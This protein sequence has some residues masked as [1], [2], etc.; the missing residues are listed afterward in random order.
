MREAA[1]CRCQRSM[2]RP[3]PNGEAPALWRATTVLVA[4]WL[5]NQIIGYAV[6]G[7]PRT[8][9]SV[10]WGLAIGV[11]AVASTMIAQVIVARRLAARGLTQAVVAL[12]GTFAVYEAALSSCS[13]L[14]DSGEQGASPSRSSPCRKLP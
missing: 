13:S 6:L 11:A 5:A 4:L 3:P 7:Y 8:A 10:M 1:C 9:N 14:R 12:G 2:R